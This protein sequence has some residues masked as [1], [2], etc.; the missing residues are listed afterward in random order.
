MNEAYQH[1]LDAFVPTIGIWFTWWLTRKRAD[2][3]HSET[4]QKQNDIHLLVNS[5]LTEALA[6]IQELE[7]HIAASEEETQY[8]AANHLDEE[9]E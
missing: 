1:L 3:N 4:T 5:R 2:K 9:R 6:K 8:R 7:A